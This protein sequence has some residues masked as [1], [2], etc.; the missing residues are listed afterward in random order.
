MHSLVDASLCADWRWNCNLGV[1]GGHSNYLS[2][3]ARAASYTSKFCSIIVYTEVQSCFCSLADWTCNHWVVVLF[4]SRNAFAVKSVRFCLMLMQRLQLSFGYT[5][6][7]PQFPLLLT[8]MHPCILD[9]PHVRT[10][11]LHEPDNK[12]SVTTVVSDVLCSLSV[13]C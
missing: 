1:S 9:I 11:F 5:L 10:V 2:Y 3:L 13:F 6:H 12:S 7:G 8:F 4:I